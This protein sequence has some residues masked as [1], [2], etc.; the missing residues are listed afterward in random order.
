M[1]LDADES[2]GSLTT[3]LFKLPAGKLHVNVTCGKNAQ[4]TAQVVEASGKVLATSAPI[5]GEQ[6]SGELQ[7]ENAD[8][9]TATGKEVQL[10][11]NLRN[12][13]FY[14]YWFE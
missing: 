4:L 1:S 2:G 13:Q 6:L 14:S 3:K 12:G 9:T 10:R 8:L 11:F 5:S 7:W